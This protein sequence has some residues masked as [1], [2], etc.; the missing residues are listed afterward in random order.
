MSEQCPDGRRHCEQRESAREISPSD[1]LPAEARHFAP[2]ACRRASGGV[3][4]GIYLLPR[5]ATMTPNR[6]N[7]ALPSSYGIRSAFFV[8][9]SGLIPEL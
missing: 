8:F 7:P 4:P 3:E 9:S 5:T 2:L 1:R 6:H